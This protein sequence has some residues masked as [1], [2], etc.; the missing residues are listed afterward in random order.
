MEKKKEAGASFFLT[1]P[2]FSEE[3]MERIAWLKDRIDTKILCGIMPLVS[4]KNA[5]FIQNEI[6]GVFV[7]DEIVNRYHPE[8]SR[9]EAEDTAVALAEELTKKMEMH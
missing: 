8:M 7:P 1:Q 5:K 4:Y 2:V 3:D 6:T 9:E